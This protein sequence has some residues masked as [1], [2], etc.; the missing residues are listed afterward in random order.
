MATN[1]TSQSALYDYLLKL[2]L[3]GDSGVGKSCI[4]LRWHYDTFESNYISTIGVDFQIKTVEI[5]GVRVKLQIWDTAGQDRF[6]SITTS[7][8]RG[9]HGIVMVYDVTDEESFLNISHWVCNMERYADN[10]VCAILMGNKC[11]LEE[12][13]AVSKDRGMFAALE[14]NM[15]FFETSAKSDININE[16]FYCIAR[17]IIAKKKK[18]MSE[19]KDTSVSKSVKSKKHGYSKVENG[20]TNAVNAPIDISAPKDRPK[21]KTRPCCFGKGK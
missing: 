9:A 3:I 6:R 16:T 13:R 19:D 18:N 7:Y 1:T 10:D 14:N 2:L 17:E 15:K 4:L 20:R 8:Y 12:K 5:D 21:K 11:D